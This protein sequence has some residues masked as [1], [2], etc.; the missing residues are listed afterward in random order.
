[1]MSHRELNLLQAF[2]RTPPGELL[3]RMSCT[4][5]WR[6]KKSALQLHGLLRAPFFLNQREIA[7]RVGSS[8]ST[9]FTP[10]A[11]V[12]QGSAFSNLLFLIYISDIYYPPRGEGQVSQFADDL[13]YW[14]SSKNPLYAGKKLQRSINEIKELANMWR[15][16]INPSKTQ[17]VLFSKHPCKNKNETINLKLY[18]EHPQSYIRPLFEYAMPAWCNVGVPPVKLLISVNNVQSL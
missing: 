16:K 18:G 8:T 9:R 17:C 3:L 1:L 13:C 15:V 4:G 11:G 2:E 6:W 10:E 5:V 7:V 12:P 14:A